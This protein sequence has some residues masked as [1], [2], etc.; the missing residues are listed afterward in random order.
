MTRV[1]P[2]VCALVFFSLL[3]LPVAARDLLVSS[4]GSGEIRRFDA[5]SGAPRGLFIGGL[6]Q[7][8]GMAFGPDGHLYVTLMSSGTI[9]KFD[10]KSGAFLGDFIADNP[11]TPEDESG[12]SRGARS[13]LF[14]PDGR[15]YVPLG[16]GVNKVVRFDAVTGRFLDVFAEGNGMVAP[17]SLAFGPDGDLYVAGALSNAIYVF[18][19]TDGSFVRQFTCGATNRNLTGI[20]FTDQE[21]LLAT[22]SERESIMRYDPAA[23]TCLG[24]FASGS[25]IQVPISLLY[26]PD[27]SLILAVSLLTD[28]VQKLDPLTGASLGTLIGPAGLLVQPHSIVLFPEEPPVT[29]KRR[30][31]VSHP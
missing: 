29:G 31:S 13:L 6:A 2:L 17:T 1:R 22:A 4:I 18:R 11:S 28:S 30:R 12:G 19:G 7:P 21:Q 26:S 24:V 3:S 8:T 14:G 27:R 10:G 23:G 15:L 16:N 9:K 25:H 5:D 20:L